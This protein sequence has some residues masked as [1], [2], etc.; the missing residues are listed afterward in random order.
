TLRDVGKRKD[1][2]I[3]DHHSYFVLT[4]EDSSKSL[5]NHISNVSSSL[6]PLLPSVL[7]TI[8]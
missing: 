6:L 2:V 4:S 8:L 1:F 7:V 3:Q 5:G